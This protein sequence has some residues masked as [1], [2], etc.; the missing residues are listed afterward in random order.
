MSNVSAD[1][2]WEVTR[3]QNAF[4]VKRKTGGSPQFS[5]DPLNL[6]NV[7]SRKALGVTATEKGVQVLSK[8]AG[9]ANKPASGLTSVNYGKTSRKTY[10][11]VARQAAA[12]GYRSDLREAAVARA[13]AIRRSQRA[14]KPSPEPK[15]RG[16][17]A[18]RAAAKQ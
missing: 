6:T 4:L 17:A 13:S 18:K 11:A 1:L 16:S 14:V 7:H 12:N 15:L 9:S 2:I 10:K 8:K 3:S 5:R